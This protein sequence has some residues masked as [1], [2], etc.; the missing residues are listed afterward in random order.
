MKV[1]ISVDM[2]GI[3]GVTH[4]DHV[5][6]EGVE[7][8]AA[9][10]WMTAETNAAVEGALEAGASE[11]VVADSHG[12]M[13]NLLPDMLHEEALLVRGSPRPLIQME[14]L[15]ESFSAAMFIGYH[16]GAGH[17]TGILAHT[18][19]S[20]IVYQL[21]LNGEPVDESVFNASVAGEVGVPVVLVAGD[22]AL[23]AAIERTLPWAERVVTKWAISSYAA[24]NLSPAASQKRIREAAKAALDQLEAMKV[25]KLEQPIRFEANFN[26]PIY[27]HLAADI[28][29]AE[30]VDGY[31][32]AFEGK[33]MLEIS[34]I[35]RLMIN[36]S[37]SSFMV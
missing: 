4:G 8:E 2:E 35:W 30:R 13:R 25:F 9:R 18:H 32:V 10:K 26:H 33:D 17:A 31:T 36:A 11:V 29:G 5:K 7:Y 14:G 3:A 15:D 24:R 12:H 19:V 37:L 28:P 34:R 21:R 1:F 27:A 23:A 22:D 20:R 16:A 6:L